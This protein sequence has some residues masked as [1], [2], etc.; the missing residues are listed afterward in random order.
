[1]NSQPGVKEAKNAFGVTFRRFGAIYVEGSDFW[2]KKSKKIEI[3]TANL[4]NPHVKV[5][6]LGFLDPFFEV[7]ELTSARLGPIELRRVG[8][9]LYFSPT[10]SVTL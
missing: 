10:L 8:V 3:I 6:N 5:K 7:D 4:R 2:N 9:S 1:M